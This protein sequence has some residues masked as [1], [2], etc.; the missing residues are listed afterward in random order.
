MLISAQCPPSG[1]HPK[2]KEVNDVL[3]AA[4]TESLASPA[5]EVRAGKTKKVN[6]HVTAYLHRVLTSG[7]YIVYRT[8][9]EKKVDSSVDQTPKF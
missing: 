3:E 6:I 5:T 4:G 9:L 8:T 2:A 1:V 7:Y